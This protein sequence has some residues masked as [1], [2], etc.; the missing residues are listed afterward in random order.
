MPIRRV[1]A[2]LLAGALVLLAAGCHATATV[3]ITVHADGSGTVAL[4]VA[5]DPEA[6]QAAE[7]GAPLAQ[8][9]RLDDLR[10][11]GWTVSAWRTAP[12]GSARVT[13]TKA[14]RTPAQLE[15]TV[16][17]LNGRDGPLAG[18]SAARDAAWGGLAH[19]V[20]VDGTVDLHRARPGVTA[21]PQLAQALAAQHVDVAT[22]EADLAG[23]LGSSVTVRVDVTLPDGTHRVVAGPGRRVPLH[24]AATSVDVP[25]VALAAAA[26]LLVV[27]AALAWR[28]GRTARSRRARRRARAGRRA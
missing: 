9:V 17:Q 2:A 11:A 6:V 16:A 23:Q 21:D 18:F 27:L 7:G 8:R 14:F 26:V 28:R 12:D 4:R 1:A 20:R 22:I 25:R 13:L 10:Q 5:L 15:A 24:A 3:G 19:T